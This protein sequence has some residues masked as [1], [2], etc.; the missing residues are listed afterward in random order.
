MSFLCNRLENR[1]CEHTDLQ[2]LHKVGS[3][4]ISH[5][6]RQCS[7]HTLQWKHGA[8]KF[9]KINVN[10]I[11]QVGQDESVRDVQNAKDSP[12]HLQQQT[13]P[14]TPVKATVKVHNAKICL[15]ICSNELSRHTVSSC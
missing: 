10:N 8:T 9:S 13:T 6:H 2:S 1:P 4:G 11:L 3:N 14:L 7:T 15:S 12:G 5:Q